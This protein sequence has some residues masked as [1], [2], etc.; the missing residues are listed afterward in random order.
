MKKAV[1]ITVLAAASLLAM[2]AIAQ[3]QGPA[4]TATPTMAAIADAMGAREKITAVGVVQTVDL[5]NR[6]VSI[7]NEDGKIF[8]IHAGP[9]V[10]NLAQIGPGSVVKVEYHEALAMALEKVQS[11]GINVREDTV[12]VGRTPAGALPGATVEESVQ[13]IGTILAIDKA[14]RTVLIQGAVHHVSLK[15]PANM[16]LKD[17]KAGDQVLARYVQEL[18]V[19]VGPAPT[20]SYTPPAVNKN[21]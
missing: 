15:I 9:E 14:K 5:K 17:L 2:S 20:P 4:A 19:A 7:K 18:G 13:M 21:Q 1:Q 11:G 6:L 12:S 16:D 3:G 8:T 10:R